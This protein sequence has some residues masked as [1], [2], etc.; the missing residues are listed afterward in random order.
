MA[1][2]NILNNLFETLIV[3]RTLG[4]RTITDPLKEVQSN[5]NHVRAGIKGRHFIESHLVRIAKIENGFL[6]ARHWTQI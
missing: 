2:S 3:Y 6:E 5:G 4:T 1:L